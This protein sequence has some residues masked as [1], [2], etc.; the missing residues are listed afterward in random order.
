ML[1]RDDRS[2]ATSGETL[3]ADY[4]LALKEIDEIGV[5]V[6]VYDGAESLE[7]VRNGHTTIDVPGCRQLRL[8]HKGDANRYRYCAVALI[9][10]SR[11]GFT[12]R[13]D[14]APIN[15]NQKL[16]DRHWGWGMQWNDGRK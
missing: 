16:V 6:G 9:Q 7:G 13:M 11:H 4:G 10:Q 12:V 2:G 8:E 1:D 14:T 5:F 3:R 15:G